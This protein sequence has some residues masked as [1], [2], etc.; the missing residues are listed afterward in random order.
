M[1]NINK[2]NWNS[3]NGLKFDGVNDYVQVSKV[4]A[5]ADIR[6]ISFWMKSNST[7]NNET[8]IDFG[9]TGNSNL[10]AWANISIISNILYLKYVSINGGILAGAYI[11]NNLRDNNLHNVVCIFSGNRVYNDITGFKCYVDGVN[12]NLTKIS[13]NSNISIIQGTARIGASTGITT[14]F[15]YKN[16]LYDLKIFNKEL[17]QA[18]VSELYNKQGQIVPASAV[19]SLQADYRFNNKSGTIL[20]DKSPNNYH[21]TLMNYAIE[22]TDL[23]ATNSW[24]DKY[25][26]P[27]TSY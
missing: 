2:I 22:T 12:I 13:S 5:L 24:V 27:L 25:G 21:G 6:T 10:Y 23:G 8:V 16:Y 15:Y 7:A 4:F 14:Q 11:P 17:S 19:S 18:E 9:N 1:K 26:N 20:T 3:G